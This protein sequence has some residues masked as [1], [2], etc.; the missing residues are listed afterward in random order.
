MLSKSYQRWKTGALLRAG[1]G[2]FSSFV[3]ESV[4]FGLSVLPAV[5]FWEW[6]L[7]WRL[8]TPFWVRVMLLSMVFVPAYLIFAFSL[9]VLSALSSRLLGW[10]APADAEMPLSDPGWPLIN[11]GRY[12][13][14]MHLVR[15]FAGLVFRSTPLWTF[16][17]RL[18]GARLGKRV[19]VNSLWV[20]DHNLLEF[21]DDVVIGSEVHLSGHT[22]ER[23]LV[24]TAR[25]RLGNGVTVGVSSI[26]DI[27]VEAGPGCQIGAMSLVPKFSKLEA[28]QT[29]VGIPV[30]R[31]EPQAPKAEKA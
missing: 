2:V 21:G 22:V 3:V 14:S 16:Y 7:G 30:H 25:V 11:W 23:G 29:Y 12:T 9:M 20:T 28:G 6:H 27:G 31:L 10:R 13:I 8:P 5:L 24:K 17:M 1:W 26:V 4:V 19:F 18:N 15:V